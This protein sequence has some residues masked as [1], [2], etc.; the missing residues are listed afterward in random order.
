MP[1]PSW[2]LHSSQILHVGALPK[3]SVLDLSSL[4]T[5]GRCKSVVILVLVFQWTVI[6]INNY[7][8]HLKR[9]ER[10]THLQLTQLLPDSST[11]G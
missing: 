7:G 8:T 2:S 9:P 6:Q 4:S 3:S 11:E 1:W 5:V 10:V